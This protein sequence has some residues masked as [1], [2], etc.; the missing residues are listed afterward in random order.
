MRDGIRSYLHSVWVSLRTGNMRGVRPRIVSHY[1]NVF[2]FGNGAKLIV[3]QKLRVSTNWT[4]WPGGCFI[5]LGENS[6]LHFVGHT[7]MCAGGRIVLSDGAK[8]VIGDNTIL[9]DQ[10]WLRVHKE[11]TIGEGTVIGNGT[12][13][14]DTDSH[15]MVVDGEVL[16]N[17]KSVHIGDRV[18][19][20]ARCVVLKG[21]EIGDG[22]VIGAMSLVTKAVPGKMLAYGHPAECKK[23]IDGWGKLAINNK[24]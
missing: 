19:I 2:R 21:V 4:A 11:V 7:K 8:C 9:R 15:R 22:A 14:A 10:F 12:M 16:D 17:C 3:G 18:W 23:R 20:G 24:Q 6:T 1:R 5:E 13:V